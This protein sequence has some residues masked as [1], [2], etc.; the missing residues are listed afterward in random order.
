MLKSKFLD[1]Y[2]GNNND[3]KIADIEFGKRYNKVRVLCYRWSYSHIV[4][5]WIS[6]QP[7]VL[8]GCEECK[9][10][11]DWVVTGWLLRLRMLWGWNYLWMYICIIKS[12]SSAGILRRMIK[13][14]K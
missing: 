13:L 2:E 11:T 9:V 5:E 4:T 7:H 6:Q 8:P 14:P 3:K 1:M 12:N 10:G